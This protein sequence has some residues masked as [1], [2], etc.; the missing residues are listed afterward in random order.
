MHTMINAMILTATS[1]SAIAPPRR[2]GKVFLQVF[3][4]LG[5]LCDEVNIAMGEHYKPA[6]P[7]G[8]TGEAADVIN[9][10]IDYLWVCTK[11]ITDDARAFSFERIISK[12]DLE[13]FE[14]MVPQPL[15]DAVSAFERRISDLSRVR[16]V[17][18]FAQGNVSDP[19]E[20]SGQIYSDSMNAAGYLIRNVL[21]LVKADNPAITTEEFL[22]IF[23][24]KCER[25]RKK[26]CADTLSSWANKVL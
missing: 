18:N 23:D 9:S 7:D 2:P 16:N 17:E 3:A 13:S 1:V 22:R 4:E 26:A 19:D 15:P 20:A 10:L 8:I 24:T 5:E 21:L 12:V 11:D 25:W 6:G 14:D